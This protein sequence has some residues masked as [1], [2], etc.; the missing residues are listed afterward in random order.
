[1]F[2]C[3]LPFDPLQ[4]DISLRL[5]ESKAL[6]DAV[7]ALQPRDANASPGQRPDDVVLAVTQELVSK[8]PGSLKHRKVGQTAVERMVHG[9]LGICR[10]P[11]LFTNGPCHNIMTKYSMFSYGPWQRQVRHGKTHLT[12]LVKKRE[13]YH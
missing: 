6:L 1:M 12:H 4:A 8:I 3:L 5:K 9:R 11:A 7:L 13:Y 10:Q 2:T